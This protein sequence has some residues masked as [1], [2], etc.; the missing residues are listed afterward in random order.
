[1]TSLAVI[2]GVSVGW[3]LAGTAA[4]ALPVIAHLLARRGGR[5]VLFPAVWFVMQAAAEYA[6]RRRLRDRLLLA[7]RLLAI[8]LLAVAFDRPTWSARPVPPDE[9]DG[10]DVVI[11]LDASAS[12]SRTHLGRSIWETACGEARQIISELDPSRDR[13]GV[14]FATTTSRTA[15]PRL[16]G[17]FDALTRAVDDAEVTLEHADLSAAIA[18]AA[19]TPGDDSIESA[20][21]ARRI[22][23]V[24][25]RSRGQWHDVAPP[26]GVDVTLRLI[27]PERTTPNLA[28]VDAT[29]S[30]SRPVVGQAAIFSARIV[31]YGEAP[32][33]PTIT[34]AVEGRADQQRTASI[35]ADGA[36]TVS[37]PVTFS[38]PGQYAATLS[39]VDERTTYD[40]VAA[41]VAD[42][43]SSRRIAI[44]TDAQSGDPES[45]LYYLLTALDPG[46]RATWSPTLLPPRDLSTE[47][48]ATFDA[49]VIINAGMLDAPS[50]DALHGAIA[51]GLG[52]LWII[53]SNPAHV[54]MGTFEA[55]DPRSIALP[56]VLGDAG[57][58]RLTSRDAAR[59]S[60]GSFDAPA[61]RLLEGGAGE[62]VLETAALR[63]SPAS[64][65]DTGFE[66]IGFDSGGPFLAWSRFGDGRIATMHADVAPASCSLVKSPL[67]PV[68]LH[69]IAAFVAPGEHHRTSSL[70]GE[71]ILV[72]SREGITLQPPV[73]DGE[74]RQVAVLPGIAGAPPRIQD[75]PAKAPGILRYF[76][77][78][79]QPVAVAAANIDER[80]TDTRVLSADEIAA[81]FQSPS[82]AGAGD[83]AASVL[84]TRPIELWPWLIVG[85]LGLLLIESLVA[86]RRRISSE[87]E[88]D[89]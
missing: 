52:V 34:C 87:S 79:G 83:A 37:F 17:N 42:A 7:L 82:L 20:E 80:E 64:V 1:M 6:R 49:A 23:L 28:I 68:L 89:A 2:A 66:L 54:A 81:R 70:V 47:L 51:V 53:D 32:R 57:F 72:R 48:L 44:I 18:L 77:A 25:D 74:T 73:T 55:I 4:A 88:D 10:R 61:L 38:Q 22:V 40:D 41:V 43:R 3:I 11:I 29:V 85:V 16:T 9:K 75:E 24:S 71:P 13:A 31:N 26:S 14:V 35:S 67:F 50:L 62:S 45:G 56:V 65:S 12:M 8:L 15:L 84:G 46:E 19:S 86:N 78:D 33:S 63:V 58:Q 69:E 59:L 76:D 39:L 30:P 5:A 36:T 27:G 21:R 60:R